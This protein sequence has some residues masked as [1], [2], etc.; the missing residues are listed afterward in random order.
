MSLTVRPSLYQINTWCLLQNLAEDQNNSKNLDDIPDSDLNTL[1]ESGSNF[2]S[3]VT[4][5]INYFVRKRS[6]IKILSH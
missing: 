1:S 3:G 2:N 5:P 4:I 6:T